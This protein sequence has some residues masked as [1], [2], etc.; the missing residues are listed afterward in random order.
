MCVH[1]HT[2]LMHKS[3]HTFYDESIEGAADRFLK[4]FKEVNIYWKRYIL[5]YEGTV[6]IFTFILNFN[7][8]VIV[9]VYLVYCSF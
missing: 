2:L 9:T 5:A 6:P 1:I 3:R 4:T 8:V 7:V